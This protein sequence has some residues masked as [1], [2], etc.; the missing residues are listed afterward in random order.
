MILNFEIIGA[1]LVVLM[2]LSIFSYLYGDNFFY[3]SAEHI[4]VGVSAGYIFAITFWD[5]IY[6][7]LLGRLFPSFIDAGYD[8]DIS[9]IIP[10]I[11]GI[12]MILRLVPNLSWLAR[13]SI[14]YIVGM[15]AGLKFYVFI[16]S[17]IL[18]Q[19]KSSAIDFSLSYFEIFNQLIILIGVICGL[20]YF[21]FSKEHNGTIGKISKLGVY[22]LMIK[23]GA[24]FGFAVM[25]RIS[26]LIGRFDEL[27]EY[28]SVNYNYATPI[29]FIIMV[30]TLGYWSF[31]DN[32]KILDNN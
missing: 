11:L 31:R 23:F 2:T 30:I 32:K 21:F 24:S 6:P 18:F 28:S 17:N 3:K 26:L 14:A 19:I 9:Y 13:I 5:Q 15:A 4:F 22:F 20:I 12:F 7:N 1:W 16:N 27:I 25:G 10:L 29:I 8:F